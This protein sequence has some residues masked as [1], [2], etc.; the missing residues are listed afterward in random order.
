[1]QALAPPQITL[2]L[3][4]GAIASLWLKRSAAPRS[5]ASGQAPRSAARR[6]DAK[7][8]ARRSRRN[9]R[10]FAE[11]ASALSNGMPFCCKY[12]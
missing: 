8:A 3:A 5:A 10:R 4:V 11:R 7:S 2:M 6:R 9:M 12:E 1:M